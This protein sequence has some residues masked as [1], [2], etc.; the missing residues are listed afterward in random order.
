M[1][2]LFAASPVLV[3]QLIGAILGLGITFGLP[4][5][6]AQKGALVG[7]VVILDTMFMFSSVVSPKTASALVKDAATQ[8]AAELTTATVGAKTVVTDAAQEVVNT[9]AD[10]VF[11]SV[12]GLAGSLAKVGI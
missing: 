11:D 4:I 2:K 12:G 1:K 3:G 5:T 9:V 6:D 10:T 8:T 7:L